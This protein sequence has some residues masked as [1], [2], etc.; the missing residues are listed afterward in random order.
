MAVAVTPL[1]HEACETRTETGQP[2]ALKA[3]FTGWTYVSQH[4]QMGRP[5]RSPIERCHSIGVPCCFGRAGPLTAAAPSFGSGRLV[6]KALIVRI[7]I[8]RRPILLATGSDIVATARL[9]SNIQ[10]V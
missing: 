2:L 6:A 8:C 10:A 9:L 1:A 3:P 7:G 4:L 5:V